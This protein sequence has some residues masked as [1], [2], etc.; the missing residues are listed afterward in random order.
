MIHTVER[1]RGRV[2]PARAEPLPPESVYQGLLDLLAWDDPSP[3]LR[4]RLARYRPF[5]VAELEEQEAPGGV[6]SEALRQAPHLAPRVEL[7]RTQHEELLRQLDALIALLEHEAPD[8]PQ[9]WVARRGLRQAL[10][11]HQAAEQ[12]LVLDAYFQDLGGEG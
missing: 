3:G 10:R 6:L 9:V 4:Q 5:F 11:R 2:S 12:D 8:S 7:C 1:P